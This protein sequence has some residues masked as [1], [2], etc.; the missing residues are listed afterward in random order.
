MTIILYS[1]ITIILN[2]S[3][4]ESVAVNIFFILWF[5]MEKNRN[6]FVY[7]LYLHSPVS[8]PGL[9]WK[10]KKRE[11]LKKINTEKYWRRMKYV[12]EEWIFNMVKYWSTWKCGVI[13]HNQME[14]FGDIHIW[15]VQFHLKKSKEW[16]YYIE[17]LL[18]KSKIL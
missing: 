13:R 15:C 16:F 1:I 12:L 7:F 14:F 5:E 2:E 18:C 9:M 4:L 17:I 10:T 8:S 3:P 6:W 11:T